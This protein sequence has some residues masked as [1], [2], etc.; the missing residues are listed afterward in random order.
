MGELVETIN[1]P[2]TNRP[3]TPQEPVNTTTALTTQPPREFTLEFLVV[4]AALGV[5]LLVRVLIGRITIRIPQHS[6]GDEPK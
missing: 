1:V 3:P 4:G 2:L 6:P 5:G